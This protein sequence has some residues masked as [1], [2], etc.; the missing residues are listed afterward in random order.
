MSAKEKMYSIVAHDAHDDRHHGAINVPIYQTSLFSFDTYEQFNMAR[1]DEQ[2]NFVYSR[3]NNPTVRYLEDK[4]AQLEQGERAK[5]FS[6]GMAAISA[7]IMSIVKQGDHVICTH[8]A[9]GPTRE[10]LGVYL[11]KFG[12]ETTF[13]DGSS[14][15]NWKCTVRPNTKLL[16]LESPTSMMFQL[17][18]IRGCTALAQSIGAETILDNS[19]ATPCHQNPLMMGVSLVIHSITKYISGHSD[20]VG[21]V[22]IGSHRLM[23]TLM[24][25]EYMLFGGI[26]TPQ[27]AGLVTR[28]LRTLP[29][30]MQRHESSGLRVVEYLGRQHYVRKVNHPGL[31][32]HPQHELARTQMYGYSSLFS[33]ESDEP[34]VK[35]RAWADHL[36]YFRIGAS[37]GGFESLINVNALNNNDQQ[38]GSLVR[39][40]IGSEDPDDLIRDMEEA[41]RC[42]TLSPSEGEI[43]EQNAGI[44]QD[45]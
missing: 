9:Y 27:T 28:G 38:T 1:L 32:N 4:L 40:Y 14:L 41:W 24:S 35:L 33:F 30:R 15:E 34:V 8:Q 18:D 17:Q 45:G 44:S 22:V 42:V 16:Y 43:Y 20:C 3:G 12:V 31:T 10:F 26:M 6:S 25:T 21:G 5:C 19:W 37:W 7:A 11:Q 36:H 23:D 29:M 2:E 39:L 13:V